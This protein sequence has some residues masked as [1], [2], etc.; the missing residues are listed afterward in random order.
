MSAVLAVILY[1]GVYTPL[2]KKTILAIL[3][4]AICGALPPYIGWLSGGGGV[5]NYTAALLLAL[6]FL[7]QVPH[8]WLVLL[9]F[10]RDY[11]KSNIPNFL[12]QFEEHRLRRYFVTWIGALVFVMLMFLTLPYPIGLAFRV[13]VIVNGFI[14]LVVFAYCLGIRKACNYRI[15]FIVLNCSLF[16]HML[17]F[18]AGRIAGVVL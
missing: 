8:F 1:N 11:E 12:R 7:W 10:K 18:G 17:V 16:L 4:G 2:K 15:L 3:P 9:T 14:L 5:V 13:I 6:F